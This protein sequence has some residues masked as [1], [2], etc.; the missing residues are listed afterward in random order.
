MLAY[1]TP[2]IV[3]AFV[4]TSGENLIDFH[5]VM[6][7]YSKTIQG[8]IHTNATIARISRSKRGACVSYS[9]DGH[10]TDTRIQKCSALVLA[11]P[12]TVDALTSAG[13][14]VSAEERELFAAVRLINYFS[15]AVAMAVPAGDL[16]YANS[17]SPAVPPAAEGQPVGFIRLFGAS[18]VVTTWSWGALGTTYTEAQARRVLLEA[19]A[20]VNK[21]AP[22]DPASPTIPLAEADIRAFRQHDY[23]PHVSGADLVD[24]WYARFDA[25]QGTENTYYASGLNGF[26]M[27]EYALRAGKDVVD[28]Y[29]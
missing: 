18:D 20:R 12:P 4:G 23:F 28:T 25:L 9:L 21:P 26:E 11:F 3:G 5:A 1:F 7:D 19:L 16:Y 6:R 22:A 8:P 15:G 27:V 17:T 10:D 13:L 14:D 24:G 29:F 2:T